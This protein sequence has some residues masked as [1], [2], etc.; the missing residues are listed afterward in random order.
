ADGTTLLNDL[1]QTSVPLVDGDTITIKGT[2]PD[3]SAVD[4]VYTY[5]AGDDVQA[6]LDR[7]NALYTGTT[8]SINAKGEIV[9]T[10]TKYGESKTTISLA[11][12]AS[13]TGSISLPSF[14]RSA[15]GFSPKTTSS[16]E[17]FDSLGTTHTLN[18]T[19]TKT[20]NPRE[21]LF[22]A[23]LSGKEVINEGSKGTLTFKSDGSLERIIYDNGQ[24][25]LNF[26]PGNGADNVSLNLDFENTT[27]FS[28]LT[29]FAGLSSVSLPYQDGQANGTLTS[30]AIDEKGRIVGSFSNGRNRLIA[31]LALA[32]VSNPEGLVHIGNNIYEVSGSSGIPVIGK[33]GEEISAT[34]LSGTLEASNVD[35]AAEFAEMIIAQR[36]FQA[37][38]RVITVSDQFLSEVTQLKR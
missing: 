11:E 13:N 14:M 18:I 36:A 16:I 26:T 3:G 31:Q 29:Q 32:K 9:L 30:F 20:E 5:S 2:N 7:I 6:L 28:G 10:D 34:T 8:A 24:S 33:A 12:G 4:D 25:L 27:G 21:W 19:F 38:A 15:K 17:V 1:D 35:L 23:N 37:N 22:E